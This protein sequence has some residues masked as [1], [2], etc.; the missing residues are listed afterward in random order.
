MAM[1]EAHGILTCFGITFETRIIFAHRTLDRAHAYASTLVERGV[2][3][4]ITAAGKAAH[5]T[6]LMTESTLQPVS[7]LPVSRPVPGGCG[8]L[9]GWRKRPGSVPVTMAPSS[10]NGMNHMA[11]STDLRI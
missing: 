6:G 5:L 11:R 4:V 2:K 10:Q 9:S 7:I 3:I 1:K 8:A